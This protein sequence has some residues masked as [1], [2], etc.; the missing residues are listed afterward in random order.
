MNVII[1]FQTKMDRPIY[2]NQNGLV[3]L[4]VNNKNEITYYTQT[5][6]GDTETLAEKREL[7]EPIKEIET[8]YNGNELN[9]GDDITSVKIGFNT[10]VSF[11]GV[12]IIIYSI[13]N[14]RY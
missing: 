10:R 1:Y 14:V 2:F 12:V 3:L 4:F 5:K 9:Q 8:L 7:I 11:E 13:C 6:L